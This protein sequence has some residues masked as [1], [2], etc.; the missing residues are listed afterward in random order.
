MC[1]SAFGGGVGRAGPALQ[2]LCECH[3]SDESSPAACGCAPGREQRFPHAGAARV[4][5]PETRSFSGSLFPSH[6]DSSSTGRVIFD[7]ARRVRFCSCFPWSSF[8]PLPPQSNISAAKMHRRHVS[9][10]RD[11]CVSAARGKTAMATQGPTATYRR[12]PHVRM[13]AALRTRP[14]CIGGRREASPASGSQLSGSGRCGLCC[15]R[16]CSSIT[17]RKQY[18]GKSCSRICR[19][20]MCECTDDASTAMPPLLPGHVQLHD[21]A[22]YCSEDGMA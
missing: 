14:S 5:H 11:G 4:D 21:D 12:R 6:I 20:S 8:Q 13:T 17:P 15:Y 9:I 1:G 10:Q 18:I 19:G 7:V 22:L 3:S 16:H 2:K